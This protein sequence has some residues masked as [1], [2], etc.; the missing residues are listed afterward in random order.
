MIFIDRI[1]SLEEDILEYIKDELDKFPEY[2]WDEASIYTYSEV[3]GDVQNSIVKKIW[4]DKDEYNVTVQGCDSTLE[5]VLFISELDV[6]TLAGIAD[7]LHEL[8]IK[9]L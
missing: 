3:Q 4:K 6:Y 8:S 1:N 7:Q 2:V 9:D 5:D